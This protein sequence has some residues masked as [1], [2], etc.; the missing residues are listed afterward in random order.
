MKIINLMMDLSA[1]LN[2]HRAR[3][4][5]LSVLST[6]LP[7]WEVLGSGGVTWAGPAA[8]PA[9]DIGPLCYLPTALITSS[10]RQ[11]HSCG[12]HFLQQEWVAHRQ[13]A[14]LNTSLRPVYLLLPPWEK[15]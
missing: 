2:W 6:A 15:T 5:M 14:A 4:Y 11:L 10:D 7:Q 13:S 12:K 9:A 3:P 1:S 8:G